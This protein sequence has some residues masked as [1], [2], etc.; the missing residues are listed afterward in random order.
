MQS[1]EDWQVT[2]D[3]S[4]TSVFRV[5]GGLAAMIKERS[6]GSIVNLA[7]IN[8]IDANPHL[9]VYTA[10]KGG[11]HALTMQIAVE[12]GPHGIRCN[13]ISPGLIV[14]RRTKV[15]AVAYL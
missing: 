1:D 14:T 2:I 5:P 8:Q 4:L 12:Y 11:V 15:A 3:A 10:A 6:G 13:A 7:S 9:S